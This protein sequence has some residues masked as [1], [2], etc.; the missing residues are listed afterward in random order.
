MDILALDHDFHNFWGCI[1]S[2]TE[3]QDRPI[4]DALATEYWENPVKCKRKYTKQYVVRTFFNGT[5]PISFHS[6]VS[7]ALSPGTAMSM[8]LRLAIF[9][10]CDTP[11][12]IHAS[13]SLSRAQLASLLGF[14]ELYVENPR[15]AVIEGAYAAGFGSLA[16]LSAH[17]PFRNHATG[18]LG[19]G[20]NLVGHSTASFVIVLSEAKQQGCIGVIVE[21]VSNQ[22]N[23]KITTPEEFRM[24]CEAC[25]ETGLLLAVDETI[26]A[27]RC[28]A[29][30]AYQ[31]SEYRDG[32]KPDLVFFGKALGA[33]GIGI[34]FDGLLL[35]RL[36]IQSPLRKRQAVNDWQAIVTQP[37]YLPV[38]VDALGVLEMAVAGDRFNT[39]VRCFSAMYSQ[40]F[41]PVADAGPVSLSPSSSCL[42]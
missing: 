14:T 25:R 38:L 31:R 32:P 37:L 19:I 36:G 29:L 13:S 5:L 26:T 9:S 7:D 4:A 35:S 22:S 16:N 34:N 8:L 18:N 27:L 30:S 39:S 24:L 12:S 41:C 21:I 17:A 42:A 23:G 3:L 40:N 6:H 1:L 10:Q 2:V 20:I 11:E 33:Q 15:W 28:G